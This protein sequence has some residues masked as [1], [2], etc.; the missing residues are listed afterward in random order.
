MAEKQRAAVDLASFNNAWYQPGS[1]LKRAL[2][3]CCNALLFHTAWFPLSRPKITLLRLFGAK[4]GKGVVLKPRVNIKYPWFLSIGDHCWIGEGVWIDCLA[5]VRLESHVCLSQE[6][7][8]LSGN[9]NYK[10]SSFDLMLQPIRLKQGAWVGARSLVLQGTVM[11]THA[12]LTAGSVATGTLEAYS[13]YQGHPARK[14]KER[15]I[16]VKG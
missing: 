5:E 12:V 6:A 2:W 14:V 15:Q 16:A 9:H 3:Y 10:T 11:E 13:I 8:I 1:K 7:L 4:I